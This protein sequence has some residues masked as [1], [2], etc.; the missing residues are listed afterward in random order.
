[1]SP[2]HPPIGPRHYLQLLSFEQAP[3]HRCHWRDPIRA[4]SWQSSNY[5]HLR[6]LGCLCYPNLQVTSP[7]TLAPRS[8]ACVFL[9]YPSA[10]K[11][12][13]CLDLS[14]R[15]VII[16]CHVVFDEFSFPFA[17]DDPVPSSFDFLRDDDLDISVPCSTNNAAVQA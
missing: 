15:C 7:H 9:G 5:D 6:V 2:C 13:R 16:S 17:R 4:P 10:H 8:T 11:G 14:T 12:Y 3:L 1:M